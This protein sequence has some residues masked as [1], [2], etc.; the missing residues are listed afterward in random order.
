[1]VEPIRRH[2]PSGLSIQISGKGREV[3]A[4]KRLLWVLAGLLVVVSVMLLTDQFRMRMALTEL[5]VVTAAGSALE[6][7]VPEAF[8]FEDYVIDRRK[9]RIGDDVL[10]ALEIQM[11]YWHPDTE[12][13]LKYVVY[14]DPETA[15]LLGYGARGVL[16]PDTR[17]IPSSAEEQPL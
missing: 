8:L 16:A 13:R 12:E 1:M 15:E 9:V 14:L 2:L 3:A 17:D 6:S 7:D 5:D 11:I 4:L 10:Q